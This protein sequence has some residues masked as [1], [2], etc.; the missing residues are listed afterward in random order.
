[1]NRLTGPIFH[2]CPGCGGGPL[3][4]YDDD[5][6]LCGRCGFHFFFN[7]SAAAVALIKDDEDRILLTQRLRDPAKG[8]LDL[9]GGFVDIGETAEA[10]LHREIMEE[11][12]VRVVQSRYLFSYPGT[13]LYD[14]VTYFILNLVF[15]CSIENFE[16]LRPGD[17]VGNYYWVEADK[18]E[19]DQIG[20][21]SI[22][23]ILQH[24]L[25][26]R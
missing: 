23:Y 2:F 15:R 5:S 11:L 20:L 12:N 4:E 19:L 25:K 10:A 18:I 3:K 9:P 13:Y 22:K 7:S 16:T 21:E 14:N 8:M 6:I 24:Y 26:T 17:D 1:M